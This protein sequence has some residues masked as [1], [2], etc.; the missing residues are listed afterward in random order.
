MGPEL[1]HLFVCTSEGA[2]EAEA[3]LDLGL[4]EGAP[5]SHPGQGT[6]CRRFFFGNAFLELL[7]VRDPDEA[8]GPGPAPTLLWERW[9]R[10]R[11]SGVSPFGICV[12]IPPGEALP[13][14]AWDYRPPY[15]P[16]GMAIPVAMSSVAP[17]DGPDA[18]TA[19]RGA[20]LRGAA[21]RDA[22]LREPMLFAFPAGR[23]PD[24]APPDRVQP[25][26][27]AAGVRE[28]TRVGLRW[29]TT[30]PSDALAALLAAAVLDS[31]PAATASGPHLELEFD[32]VPAR[33]VADLRPALPLVLRW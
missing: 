3:L 17:L 11:D 13:F 18:T 31:A 2:P 33:V 10:R 23:R 4:T 26:A 5:N 22:A 15:L 21:G 12:R 32:G 29:S 19:F 24:A 25:L 16:P 30:A 20:A 28:L 6:A 7:W 14:A 1:D 8:R 27:H 9:A